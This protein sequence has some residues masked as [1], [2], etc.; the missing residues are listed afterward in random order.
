MRTRNR[1]WVIILLRERARVSAFLR[2]FFPGSVYLLSL[3]YI[4][5]LDNSVGVISHSAL[6]VPSI[7][8]IQLTT[9]TPLPRSLIDEKPRARNMIIRSYEPLDIL[10]L[11]TVLSR[12][13]LIDNLISI[14][15]GTRDSSSLFWH[16]FR[17]CRNHDAN[18]VN[19]C[20]TQDR[21]SR[22]SLSFQLVII[23]SI[24]S[25]HLQLISVGDR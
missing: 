24:Y 25:F 13:I 6:S 8:Q 18:I 14:L 20:H 4:R 10:S 23:I 19:Q 9:I 3:R 5:M 12:G 1:P 17:I 7:I 2:S 16:G 22:Y 11:A 21:V 15:N